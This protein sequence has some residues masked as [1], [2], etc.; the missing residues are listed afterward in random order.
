MIQKHLLKD[1]KAV[2]NVLIKVFSV[3]VGLNFIQL[4]LYHNLIF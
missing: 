2:F 1:A 4:I 3:K